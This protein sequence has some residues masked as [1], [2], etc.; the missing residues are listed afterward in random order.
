M[1]SDILQKVPLSLADQRKLRTFLH[2]ISNLYFVPIS[3]WSMTLF[4]RE[5]PKQVLFTNSDD[6]DEMPHNA[7]FHK[8]LH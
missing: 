5:T 3:A 2:L 1:I 8:G 4:I 7:A 6:P